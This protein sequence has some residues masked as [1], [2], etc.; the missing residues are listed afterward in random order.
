MSKP[1]FDIRNK[2]SKLLL[3]MSIACAVASC[4]GQMSSQ[5]SMQ[6]QSDSE[7][8][9]LA[10]QDNPD[11]QTDQSK[12]PQCAIKLAINDTNPQIDCAKVF[13]VKGSVEVH[14]GLG[15]ENFQDIKKLGIIGPNEIL[16]DDVH[17]NV[18]RT[19]RGGSATSL[20]NTLDFVVV[21]E[22]AQ[23]EFSK[24][25]HVES[26]GGKMHSR[27]SL[28]F[29]KLLV[30]NAVPSSAIPPSTVSGSW[31]ENLCQA[32]K[33][34]FNFLSIL[35]INNWISPPALAYEEITFTVPTVQVRTP[36]AKVESG[37]AVYLIE[38][39]PSRKKTQ[40]YSMTAH[41]I[42][43]TDN[44]GKSVEIRRNQTVLVTQ[45]GIEENPFEFPLCGAFYRQ[46]ADVLE[47]LA[48][49]EENFVMQQPYPLQVAYH[50][51]RS[52]TLPLYHQNC[53]RICPVPPRGSGK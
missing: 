51:A 15:E 35:A 43:V 26:V 48:P 6:T 34:K 45:N 52:M 47:G 8:A 24:N 18:I 21:D 37:G 46:H 12:E 38:R 10:Q 39:H 32:Q 16:L 5:T 28:D 22:T 7:L 17:K 13:N 9:L 1:V 20:F 33:V 31:S 19:R 4:S 36:E 53:Q 23:I 30:S 25:S 2:F 42:R 27:I 3:L 11:E 14:Q 29:G 49:R 41:P 40:V 44:F 50:A